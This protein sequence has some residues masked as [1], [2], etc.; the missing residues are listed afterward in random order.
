MKKQFP[1]ITI[2]DTGRAFTLVEMLVSIVVLVL[3]VSLVMQVLNGA[4]TIAR[5]ASKHIDTDTEARTVFDR[6]AVDIG[7]MLKRTDVDYYLK[8]NNTKYPG[9][10]GLHRKGGGGPQGQTD[11]NDYMAFYSQAPGYSSSSSSSPSPISLVGYRINGLS[12]AAA[13]NKLERRGEAL[14]WNGITPFNNPTS[15]NAKPI[16]FLPVLIGDP[17]TG[18]WPAVGSNATN[19]TRDQ[20]YLETIGPNVFRFEYCYLLKTGVATDTPW[21]TDSTAGPVYG[22]FNGMSD[23]EAIGVTIAVI[24]PQSRSLLVNGD[25]N[26]NNI[27]NLQTF[28]QDFRTSPGKGVGGT[29]NQIDLE[30]QWNCVISNGTDSN[31]SNYGSPNSVVSAMPQPAIKAIRIYSRSFDLK[32]L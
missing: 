22:T 7:Q 9:K 10:S 21:N 23:V 18:V 12:T 31:C 24:D 1:T 3:L 4:A 2:Q 27:L 5:P 17:V 29:K 30:A 13:Y 19:P 32:T 6:M 16:F 26:E 25:S 11:L 15:Q 8:A 14:L 28:M 20:P